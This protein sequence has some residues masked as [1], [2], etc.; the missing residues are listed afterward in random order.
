MGLILLLGPM[1]ALVRERLARFGEIVELEPGDRGPLERALPDTVAIAARASALV[2][3]SVID[4]A[5][6]LRVIG[7]SGVGVDGVDVAAAT[8]RGIPVVITPTAG[9]N[10][11][12]EGALALI[13]HLAKRLGR[14]TQLVREGGWA[15]REELALADLDGSTLGI[16][17]YGR[18]GRRLGELATALGMRLLAYDP[19]AEVEPELAVAEL[20]D[21]V[22]R[23]DVL[24]LHA[25]LTPETRGL[26]GAALLAHVKPG[27]LL[28]N[29]GRGG[30]LDLDAAY[31]ALLDGRLA[32]VG[33]D[34]FEPEPPRGHPL[35]HHPDVVLTPHVLGLTP[36]ARRL[37]FEEMAAGM[38]AVLDG[39]RAPSVANPEV[40][41]S[42]DGRAGQHIV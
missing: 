15:A 22:A 28:V 17:G 11:V 30:L 13:L 1:D 9:T 7:R 41:G 31:E 36:R 27:C 39:R 21:L 34:V 16:V 42:T 8:R 2:D 26:V 32:G 37:L 4:A 14:L 38:A 3:A 40:Y 24:S 18:V 5:P 25:P 12:A 29:C 33:R 20:P 19:Y 6:G 35:F 23:A 10:A